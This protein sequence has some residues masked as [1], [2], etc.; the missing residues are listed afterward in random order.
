L[1]WEPAVQAAFRQLMPEFSTYLTQY[2]RAPLGRVRLIVERRVKGE[3]ADILT[4]LRQRL[5][6]GEP[7]Q[8]HAGH[9]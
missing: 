9:P 8:R 7:G 2:P 3:S 4:T 5:E 6:S 1:D